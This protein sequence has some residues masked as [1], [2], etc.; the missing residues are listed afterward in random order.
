[1][2]INY[3]L[4]YKIIHINRYATRSRY[5]HHEHIKNSIKRQT[6]NARKLIWNSMINHVPELE[7]R[8]PSLQNEHNNNFIVMNKGGLPEV[9]AVHIEESFTRISRIINHPRNRPVVNLSTRRAF[10]RPLSSYNIIDCDIIN[11]MGAYR[12][13]GLLFSRGDSKF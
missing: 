7:N 11:Y 2:P 5:L 3:L 8:T 12:R 13:G 10:F 4:T 1:M 9:K 6:L